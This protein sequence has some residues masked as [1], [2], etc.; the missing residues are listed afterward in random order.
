MNRKSFA[1]M[2][3]VAAS[4]VHMPQAASQQVTE[5]FRSLSSNQYGEQYPMVNS[6]RIVRG[7]ILAPAAHEVF[8][9]INGINYPMTKDAD[10][11]WMGQSDPLDEGNH[12]Y[13]L[14]IDGANVP[15]PASLF[16]YG[17]GAE[18]TQ[19]EIPAQDEY[20]Y[21]LRDVPHGQIREIYFH[22]NTT[23]AQ[24][25][26][27]VYTPPQYDDD[28]NVRYP[29][30]YLQH[31]YT[32]NETGWSRQGRC[33]FIMDNL[34]ADGKCLPFIIV[35]ENGEISHPA[36]GPQANFGSLMSAANELFPKILTQDV[37]PYI[38]SHFR[39]IPDKAHRALAGLS[40]GGMQTRHISLNYPG[41]FS[42][43]GIFSGGTISVQDINSNPEF[44]KE[45]TLTFIS[46]GSR[47]VENPRG[48][49][50]KE[51][52]QAIREQ[53]INAYYYESPQ[54]AHEWQTWR[55]SLYEFAP[56]LFR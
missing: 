18:R 27:F 43:I 1:I 2:C 9:Q 19:L 16:L 54:T 22:S 41:Y 53:G 44:K 35:M 38:D 21:A 8:L 42:Q 56:L 48:Q 14:V 40:M 31:G 49:S 23:G 12:Y 28:V 37:I 29:V 36:Q 17:S 51:T 20:K 46:Y 52:V 7:R 32:E 26:I 13:G 10:G 34:L 25:H 47:E 24:R 6:Q 3:V 55:R 30:L 50:P 15:D 5:D 33:G 4:V 11:Y 39:T 45:N